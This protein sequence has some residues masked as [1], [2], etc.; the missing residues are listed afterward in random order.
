M[1]IKD[2]RTAN[3]RPGIRRP[4]PNTNVRYRLIVEGI[5]ATETKRIEKDCKLLD[6]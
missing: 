3:Y 2:L 5:T 1:A 4:F 6:V